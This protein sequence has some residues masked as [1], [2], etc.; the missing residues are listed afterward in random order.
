MPSRRPIGIITGAGSGI[1]AATA[2]EF[3]RI[4]ARLVLASLS[5]DDLG[6]VVAA[7]EAAGGQ[8]V[9]AQVDVRSPSELELLPRLAVEHFGRLDF[10]FA[11]AGIL[12]HSAVADGD[13]DRWRS[14]IETNLL[15]AAYTVRAALPTMIE[16]GWGDI[17]LTASIAGRETHVGEPI[18]IASKWGLVGFGHALRKEVAP[19]GIRVI[20]IEPGLVDTPATRLDG[21]T[22]PM[23]EASEP[24]LAEDV[25]RAVVYAC[26]QPPHVVLSEV[27]IRPRRE[28]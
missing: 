16:Q 23:L 20:L 5:T 7:V 18:Y 25:A 17:V 12:D 11:N 8:A 13:P 27:T 1:G 22:R 3:A 10:L 28:P 26:T 21:V 4:G 15:G 2:V 6:T 24:L 9:P 14:V 19:H